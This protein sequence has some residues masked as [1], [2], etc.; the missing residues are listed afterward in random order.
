MIK[1]SS[2]T[3]IEERISEWQVIYS[4]LSLFFDTR[5]RI[6]MVPAEKIS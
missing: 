4:L 5:S 6:N 1:I 3:E 2:V